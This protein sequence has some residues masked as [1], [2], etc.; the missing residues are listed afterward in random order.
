[1]AI[2][3]EA[4]FILYLDDTLDGADTAISRNLN[5]SLGDLCYAVAQH[6]RLILELRLFTCLLFDP[7]VPR[8]Y[9]RLTRNVT[10]TNGIK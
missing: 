4:G 7:R 10:V 5:H 3:R 2:D 9:E 6:K 1:M 8:K